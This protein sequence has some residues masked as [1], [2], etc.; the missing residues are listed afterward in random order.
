MGADP[1]ENAVV[2]NSMDTIKMKYGIGSKDWIASPQQSLPSPGQ[3][4]IAAPV[5]NDKIIVEE[6]DSIRA[7]CMKLVDRIEK[8]E[9]ELFVK[10]KEL[11][12]RAETLVMVD[13]ER[14]KMERDKKLA[15]QEGRVR[16][17]FFL[18]QNQR[19]K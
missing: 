17:S 15:A 3:I 8:R 12:S 5:E 2:M 19:S 4:A 11:T 18:S 6:Q 10:E 14:E 9:A 1:V 13:A 16:T 7:Q